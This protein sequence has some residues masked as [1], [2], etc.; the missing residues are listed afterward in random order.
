MEE[1][2]DAEERLR[3]AADRLL[4]LLGQLLEELTPEQLDLRNVRAISSTLKDIRELQS[5]KEDGPGQ[6][7]VSLEGEIS[8]YAK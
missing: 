3:R 4:V 5:R 6:I 2:Q 7:A 1:R 8:D